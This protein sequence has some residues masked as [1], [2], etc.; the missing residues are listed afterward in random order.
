LRKLVLLSR[1][2]ADLTAITRYYEGK[3]KGLGGEFLADYWQT[4][5]RILEY[6]L[7]APAI[8]KEAR[9]VSLDIFQFN[10]YYIPK[11]EEVLVFAVMHKRRHPNSWKTRL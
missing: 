11:I 3:R 7:A 6:P 8:Y 4:I 2:K 9:K 5:V 10:I 1:A